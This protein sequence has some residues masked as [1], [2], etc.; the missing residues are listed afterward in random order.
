[1]VDRLV[2]RLITAST[3]LLTGVQARWIGCAPI[4]AERIYFANHTSH[5]DFVLIWSVLPGRLRKKTRPVAALDYWGRGVVRRYLI[6]H[7]F[8][9]VLVSRGHIDRENNPIHAM[10]Q[11]LDGETAL[12]LFPEGTRGPGGDVQPFKAG[13]YH[14]AVSRPDVELV[15][16]WIDNSYRVMPKGLPLPVP[17]LCS[18][19]FG[20]PVRLEPGEHKPEFLAR[21]RQLVVELGEA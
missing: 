16:V 11:A 13:L 5:M 4:E 19:A 21:M 7:V 17:L 9:G 20:T 6:N 18:V 14:L 10:D 8:R 3:R 12:I 15:P 1:M 2:A